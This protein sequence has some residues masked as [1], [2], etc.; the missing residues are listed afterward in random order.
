MKRHIA[1]AVVIAALVVAGGLVAFGGTPQRT[2]TAY[3]T[4]TKGLYVGDD[5]EML[6]VRIGKVTGIR[7]EPGHVRVDFS[8]AADRPVPADAKA[9]IMAPSVVPVR[10]LTLTPVYTRGPKLADGAEIP[11]SRTAVPVEWDDIKKQLDQLTSAL[12]PQGANSQGALSRLLDT[13]A[14]NLD[15]Q[16]GNLNQTLRSLSEAMATLNDGGDDLFA[17]VRNLQVFVDALAGSDA[18]VVD[19]NSRLAGVASLLHDDSGLLDTALT[20]LNSAFEQVTTFL[21]DNRQSLSDTVKDLQPLSDVLARNRQQLA[22]TLHFAPTTLSNFYNIYDP[23]DG[24]LNGALTVA[25]LQAPAMFVCSTI[26]NLGG[27][28][29]DCQNALGPLAKLVTVSGDLPVGASPLERNG[30]SNM[31]VARPGPEPPAGSPEAMR[32][33]QQLMTRGSAG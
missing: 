29:Q 21:R 5:V 25:N 17:T 18:Q 31:V 33:F 1:L 6:G 26:Y 30:R 7:P 11:L 16:G 27:S 32:G 2:A 24:S 3:F 20:S 8:Y 19:F 10:N 22:D 12:G 4:Q 14:A 9:I 13:S 15:G 28:P 23:M